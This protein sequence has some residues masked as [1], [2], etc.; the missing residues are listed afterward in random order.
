M[1]KHQYMLNNYST[2]VVSA[3]RQQMQTQMWENNGFIQQA[4][5]IIQIMKTKT[6]SKTGKGQ[7]MNKHH[8]Q[9]QVKTKT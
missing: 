7:V 4:C 6:W 9:G 1:S 2:T 3:F 8:E 5:S